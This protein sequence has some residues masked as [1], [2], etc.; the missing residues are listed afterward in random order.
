M[1]AVGVALGEKSATR[2]AVIRVAGYVLATGANLAGFPVPPGAIEAVLAGGAWISELS[3][4]RQ[5]D[6]ARVLD[7]TVAEVE[8]ELAA[9]VPQSSQMDSADLAHAKASFVEVLPHASPAPADLVGRNLTPAEI[10]ALVVARAQKA[11]PEIYV[12]TRSTDPANQLARRFLQQVIERTC[13]HLL[14]DAEFIDSLRPSLWRELLE[15]TG[16]IEG[17]TERLLDGQRAQNEQL[18]RMEAVLSAMESKLA[19]APSKEITDELLIE[20]ARR[21]SADISN[22]QQ[23]FVELEN[24]VEIAIHGRWKEREGSNLG[25]FVD[26]VLNRVSEFTAQ[27]ALDDATAAIDAALAR[28]AEEA[29]LLEERRQES[30]ARTLRLLDAGIEQDLLRRDADSAAARLVRKAEIELP[31]GASLF[32]RL[33]SLHN[34]WFE[35]GRDR[36]LNLDLRVAIALSTR[37]LSLAN[38]INQRGKSLTILGNTLQ[39]LGEREAGIELLERA[40]TFHRLVMEVWTRE[41][42]PLGWAGAQNNLGNALQELGAR[43]VGTARLE[44]AVAAYRLALEEWTRERVPL[45]WALAQNNL[46]N[47]LHTLGGR[48]ADTAQLEEA[49]AA[50]QMALEE[51]TQARTPHDWAR[52]QNSL[53]NAL[54][55]LARRQANT[56]R[57]QEA[58]SAYRFALKEWTRERTPHLWAVTQNNLASTLQQL[59]MLEPGDA[60]LKDAIVAYRLVLEDWTQERMPLQWASTQDNLGNALSI[61]G[62]REASTDRLQEAVSAYR[63]ALK[64][65]TRERTPLEWAATQSNLSNALQELGRRQH[66]TALLQEAVAVLQLVLEERTRERVPLD[67][68]ATQYNLGNA[69]AALGAREPG[70]R[71]LEEAVAAYRLALEERTRER[72]PFDWAATQNNL[73]NALQELGRREE[74]AGRLKE[75]IVAFELALEEFTPEKNRNHYVSASQN[76]ANA[77]A[78]FSG[79][80]KAQ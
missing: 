55:I 41:S 14:T 22:P 71:R 40:A 37:A 27:G 51:F 57:L 58:V 10:T 6:L 20:L 54:S 70:T 19:S 59:A 64:E 4:E 56:D 13:T 48:S 36:G 65:R 29:R 15:R 28:E 24:M 18:N 26:E 53:G 39:Q 50:H 74:S 77:R 49:V 44:E 68:A 3:A 75:A 46:G 8:A 21:V 42:E 78:I 30:R 34:E 32:G 60:N 35:H 69:L 38:D 73:G 79:L 31:E 1:R 12:D 17:N 52:A 5:R 47:A 33:V 25:P 43:E 7:R 23:A 72:V 66:D 45:L 80:L 67:W 61:L 16:R 76:L 62:I 63:L 11:R 9:W 2:E